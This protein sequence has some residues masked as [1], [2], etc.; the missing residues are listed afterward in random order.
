[1]ETREG[2]ADT[3][4]DYHLVRC[5]PITT[6]TGAHHTLTFFQVEQKLDEHSDDPWQVAC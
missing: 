6:S 2:D 3:G 4:R 5:V 1:M